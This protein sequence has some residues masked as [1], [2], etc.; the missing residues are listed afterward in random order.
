MPTPFVKP[1]QQSPQ[2]TVQSNHML[3]IP[4]YTFH[5]RQLRLS[6][7]VAI[8]FFLLPLSITIAAESAKQKKPVILGTPGNISQYKSL[9]PDSD[10]QRTNRTVEKR[11]S[12]KSAIIVDPVGNRTLFAKDPDLPRQPA[13]T[14]KVLTGTIALKSLSGKEDV[15]ISKE[16]ASRPSSKMYLD[17]K[18]SY[19]ADDLISGVLLASAND[20]SV[21]LAELIAGSED[22]FAQQMTLQAQIWGA[23][24]TVCKTATGLT[25]KGQTST[26]RDLALIFKHAMLN[27]EFRTRVRERAMET[28][29]GNKFY[30]HNKA[31]W[32]ITGTEGGKTGYTN[33]ARQTYV[34]KFKRGDAE[35]IVAIMGS[36]T[37]WNDLKYLVG[38]GFK[39]F[40]YIPA[41]AT[42]GK[43]LLAG[44]VKSADNKSIL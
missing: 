25:A 38:Y 40:Q 16:A 1:Q 41:E 31:L 36:E 24:N 30:N 39:Q 23:S 6:L 28:K 2:R 7:L 4:Y 13:S 21:A 20:A 44:E 14:I 10:L 18:Q 3:H 29:G 43:N 35:I 17:P 9:P 34:G 22:A 8:C 33:A 26:A 42:D 11:I 15:P 27:D 32:Q 5:Y 37:M 12:A 19:C